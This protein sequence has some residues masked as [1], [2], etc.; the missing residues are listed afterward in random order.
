MTDTVTITTGGLAQALGA[1]IPFA[2]RDETLPAVGA[3]QLHCL[4]DTL[5]A[6][7]TDR[8]V[9]GHARQDATG[10]FDGP[11][12][13]HWRDAQALRK[14]ISRHIAFVE[15]AA[16]LVTI[17]VEDGATNFAFGRT[18]LAVTEPNGVKSAP[19]LG[20]IMAKLPTNDGVSLQQP[21]GLS[22]RVLRPLLKAAK[23][24]P[25]NPMRWLPEDPGKPIRVEIGDWFVAAVMPVKL[26]GDE[27]N[28]PVEL[29]KREPAEQVSR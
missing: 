23:W 21:I 14:A 27:G 10:T 13:L 17:T 19:D 20:P 7:A 6:T 3:V 28:V 26:R 8:Y 24:D 25:Y 29:P 12:F 22:R 15:S 2:S 9:I 4:G 16:D 1:V 18:R 11:R 5:T